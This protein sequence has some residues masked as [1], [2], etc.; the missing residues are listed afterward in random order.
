MNKH[1]N[2]TVGLA[3]FYLSSQFKVERSASI[4]YGLEPCGVYSLIL[5]NYSRPKYLEIP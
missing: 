3:A 1:F 2:R 4:E 5:W